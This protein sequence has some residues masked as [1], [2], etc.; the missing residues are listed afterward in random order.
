M[1]A[2]T[3]NDEDHDED[4]AVSELCHEMDAILDETFTSI[5]DETFA[6]KRITPLVKVD[7]K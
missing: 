2:W 3:S 4:V 5:L 7:K 6:S 1:D